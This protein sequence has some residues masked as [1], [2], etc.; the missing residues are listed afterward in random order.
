[1]KIGLIGIGFV[2]GAMLQSFKIKNINVVAYDK[3]KKD[4]NDI[5]VCFDCDVLFLALP[6]KYNSL[7][8]EYEKSSIH[9][10]LRI[11]VNKN[12]NGIIVIKSTVEPHSIKNLSEKYK[13]NLVHNPEFLTARTAF[14][15][16]HNQKHI[17]L[18]LG[19]NCNDNHKTILS[20][21]YKKYYPDAKI[22]ISTSNESESM[23]LFINCFYATKVQFFNELYQ[24]CQNMDI[25]YNIVKNLMLKNGW[26]NPMH[27]NVPGPDGQI[28]YGGLCFP[29]DTR[30][31][32]ALM[33]KNN[34]E[35]AVLDAVINERNSMRHDQDNQVLL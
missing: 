16:F 23:K 1:M 11:L 33:K 30:A 10:T 35:H 14:E 15:D 13:L 24:L 7:T 20:N 4:I 22:S 17:L 5:N 9:E 8:H 28:S 19:Q 6:T 34:S 27:T 3:Y 29:K 21:F 25:D 18:G 32:L 2:G 26:I 31:L 12:Y